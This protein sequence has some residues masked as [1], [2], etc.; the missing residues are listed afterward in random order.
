MIA[1]KIRTQTPGDRWATITAARIGERVRKYGS[2][3]LTE[4]M[5][6]ILDHAERLAHAAIKR[7][8]QG[9]FSDDLVRRERAS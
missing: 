9:V 3:V 7:L 6:A 2:A 1:A 4:A 8:P 5:G